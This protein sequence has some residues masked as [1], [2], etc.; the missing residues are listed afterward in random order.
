MFFVS[1]V[2]FRR[3]FHRARMKAVDA[4]K[5]KRTLSSPFLTARTG[6]APSK[7]CGR[8][9]VARI[10]DTSPIF[11]FVPDSRRCSRSCPCAACHFPRRCSER[12]YLPA[13]P[14]QRNSGEEKGKRNVPKHSVLRVI[15]HS[16]RVEKYRFARIRINHWTKWYFRTFITEMSK[17]KK[18]KNTNIY[19]DI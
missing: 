13:C 3:E 8:F 18:K 12:N 5:G 19:R 9:Q 6:S 15:L 10:L 17:K 2:L 4:R 1:R 11:T 7:G 14:L 16:P